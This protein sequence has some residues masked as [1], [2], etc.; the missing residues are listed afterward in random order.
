VRSRSGAPRTW[1]RAKGKACADCHADIHRG[2]FAVEGRTDCSRCHA[3]GPDF[4][5]IVFDHERGARFALGEAHRDVA[6]A[7]CHP[8][9]ESSRGEKSVR[10]KPLPREC[11][12]CHG[13]HDEPL[14]RHKRGGR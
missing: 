6:C 4:K 11:S 12:D 9:E 7:A 3:S 13:V 8:T 2:Q 5:R 10:Y 1:S 14:L